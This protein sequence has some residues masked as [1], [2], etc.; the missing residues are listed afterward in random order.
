MKNYRK[1]HEHDPKSINTAGYWARE[2]LWS[3]PTLKEAIK[4]IEKAK[5]IKIIKE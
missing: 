3:K 4:H 2:L 5:H 1:R